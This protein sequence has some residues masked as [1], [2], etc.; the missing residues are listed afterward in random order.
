MKHDNEI[1][2]VTVGMNHQKLLKRYLHSLYSECSPTISFEVIYV[3]NCSIDG[4]VQYVQ[5]NYPQIKIIENKTIKG[6]AANNN[7]GIKRSSGKYV[8]MLNPDIILLPNAID[9]LYWF[10]KKNKSIGI[11]V[12]KLLNVDY[13]VQYSLRKFINLKIL[14]YR[15]LNNGNDNSNLPVLKDYLLTDFD[16]G[17]T[18]I[19]D[20]AL[21]AA[22]F[23]T[24]DWFDQLHGFDEGYFLYVEDIDLCL[25]SWKLGRPVVYFPESQFIHAHQRLS[26]KGWTKKKMVHIKSLIRF[27]FKHNILFRSYD[28]SNSDFVFLN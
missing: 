21:G 22:L 19:V 12:P 4:S 3:D 17:R 1:S 24:R 15:F 6:F 28:F 2:I 14:F 23:L 27:I 8:L 26:R 7:L 16:R 10:L 11:L 9:N 13:T 20:W 5:D 25:R 18:Q